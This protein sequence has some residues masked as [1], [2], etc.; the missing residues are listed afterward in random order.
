MIGPSHKH[1]SRGIPCHI[2]TC[3]RR[4]SIICGHLK[5][6]STHVSTPLAVCSLRRRSSMPTKTSCFNYIRVRTPADRTTRRN[7]KQSDSNTVFF[8]S[9]FVLRP[10]LIRLMKSSMALLLLLV[11]PPANCRLQKKKLARQ[12]RRKPWFAPW[13]TYWTKLRT[14]CP[15]IPS[16]VGS[17]T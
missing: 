12:G 15:S 8:F 1:S 4:S 11:L 10:S 6:A 13:L 9:V 7:N 3:H 2:I 16:T 5:A 14:G 17:T